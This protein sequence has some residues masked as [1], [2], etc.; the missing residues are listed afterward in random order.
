MSPVKPEPLTKSVASPVCAFVI[1]TSAPLALAVNNFEKVASAFISS[2]IS[3]AIAAVPPSSAANVIFKYPVALV[4]SVVR[5]KAEPP[6]VSKSI[7][8]VSPSGSNFVQS[9]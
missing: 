6:A 5:L 1:V 8:Y 7:T 9:T 2:A 4:P 3:V